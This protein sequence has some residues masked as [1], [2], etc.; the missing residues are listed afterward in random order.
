MNKLHKYLQIWTAINVGAG[1]SAM[2]QLFG[3]LTSNLLILIVSILGL[4]AG[5]SLSWLLFCPTKAVIR[6][7]LLIWGIQSIGFIFGG[8]AV[9]YQVGLTVKFG[10]NVGSDFTIFLNLVAILTCVAFYICLNS[11][12]TLPNSNL[13]KSVESN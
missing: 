11:Y 6:F 12:K 13:S 3:Y 1:I 10:I 4:L 2:P 7:G 8:F 9:S 5:L